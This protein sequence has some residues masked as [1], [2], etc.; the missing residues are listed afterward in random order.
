MPMTV[1]NPMRKVFHCFLKSSR[2]M[3]VP[4]WTMMKPTT[5]PAS[6]SND[7]LASRSSGKIPDRNP[8]RKI[9]EAT[10]SEDSKDL[11][12]RATNSLTVHTAM[13]TTKAT[14]GFM[15]TS[16]LSC[17]LSSNHGAAGHPGCL[18]EPAAARRH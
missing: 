14:I 11:V 3:T 15:P 8:T 1:E 13:T 4:R 17:E 6:A 16:S 12:L 18:V 7:E 9:S 10:N 2:L 5:T